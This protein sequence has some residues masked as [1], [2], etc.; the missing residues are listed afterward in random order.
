MQE[1]DSTAPPGSSLQATYWDTAALNARLDALPLAH[2]AL[3][4][5]WWMSSGCRWLSR[6]FPL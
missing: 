6:I 1:V 5:D 2:W 4:D 3:P